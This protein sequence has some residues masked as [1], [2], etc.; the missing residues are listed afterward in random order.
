MP[1]SVAPFYQGWRLMN[2]RLVGVIGSL[3]DDE[4]AWRPAPTMWPI[5]ALAGHL[6]GTRVYWLCLVL[7]EPGAASTPFIDPGEIGWEDDLFRPRHAD[8]LVLALRSTFAVVEGCLRRW[9]PEMLSAEFPRERNGAIQMHTRQSILYRLLTHDASHSGEISQTLGSH[10]RGEVDL[11][12]GLAR[13][14]P[15]T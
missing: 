1:E 8:E 15:A 14:V 13:V 2:D 9:T 4:L 3:S 7:H 6:A 10:G 5:W 11:W 12:S